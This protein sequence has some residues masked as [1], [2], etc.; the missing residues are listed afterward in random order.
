[1]VSTIFLAVVLMAIP[2]VHILALMQALRRQF[3]VGVERYQLHINDRHRCQGWAEA[4][5]QQRQI[6]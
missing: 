5:T 3:V 4:F 6:R 2:T 1:M